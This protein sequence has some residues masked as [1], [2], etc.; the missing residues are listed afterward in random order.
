AK[1]AKCGGGN[2][3]TT[4]GTGSFEA[5]LSGSS[6][7]GVMSLDGRFAITWPADEGLDA[8]T[9]SLSVVGPDDQGV[10]TVG[11]RIAAG[12]FTGALVRTSIVFDKAGS[13]FTNSAPLTVQRNTW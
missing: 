3:M 9:G 10:Y 4:T 7:A 11:G 8:S 1:I 5:T 13:T 12:A 6:Q 2:T